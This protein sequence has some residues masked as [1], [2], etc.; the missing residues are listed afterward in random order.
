MK[1][2]RI[3]QDFGLTEKEV[4][5][6]LSLLQTGPSSVQNIAQKS[7][8]A[9][10]TVYEVLGSLAK[11]NFV[12]HYQKK[13]IKHFSPEE[14]RNIVRLQQIRMDN[15]RESLP[16]LEA[17]SNFSHGRPSVRFYE[18]KEQ[19]KIVLN[20]LL[21]EADEAVCFGIAEDLLKV[22]GD[23]HDYFLKQRIKNKIPLRVILRDSPIAR[24]R[25]RLAPQHLRQVKLVSNKYDFHGLVYVWKNKIAMF[26]LMND[27]VAVVIESKELADIERSKFNNLWDLILD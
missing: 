21:N 7:G 13:K 20:E 27:I 23:Y 4:K 25:R 12:N 17:I 15:L 8:L 10:S 3:L 22:M 26:S 24:E 14:P 16:E 18:G 19:M 5:I 2:N 11:K 9:R 1:S 6:Y